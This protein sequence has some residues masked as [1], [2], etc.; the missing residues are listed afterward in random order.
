MVRQR[1]A[2]GFDRVDR[3]FLRQDVHRVLHRVG[4]DDPGVV[5][6]EIGV[7]EV[8]REQD[9]DRQLLQIVPAVGLARDLAQSHARLAVGIAE[10]FSFGH[11]SYSH[12]SVTD[13][14]VTLSSMRS[15]AILPISTSAVWISSSRECSSR[16][17]NAERIASF[18]FSR[19]QI[20][21]GNENFSRYRWLNRRR[22]STSSGLRLFRP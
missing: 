14:S 12:H 19:A 16:F 6:G 15:R 5:A 21:N 4:G 17:G 20:T 8:A 11:G 2:E 13:Y 1:R 3:V 18:L 10:Q 22:R 9:L 7:R